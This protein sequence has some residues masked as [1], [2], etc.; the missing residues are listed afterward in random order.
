MFY[1]CKYFF[2]LNVLKKIFENFKVFVFICF[3]VEYGEKK[4]IIEID[5]KIEWVVNFF[6]LGGEFNK[7][8]IFDYKLFE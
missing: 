6:F 2:S 7:I 8:L 5:L 1:F 4:D 3:Y